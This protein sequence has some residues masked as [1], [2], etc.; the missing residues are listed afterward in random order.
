MPYC[1]FKVRH[2][3][4][5]IQAGR[6]REREKKCV[7]LTPSQTCHQQ[8]LFK[9]GVQVVRAKCSHLMQASEDSPIRSSAGFLGHPS[10]IAVVGRVTFIL[11]A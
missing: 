7:A 6:E 2:F 10:D 5:S 4:W 3:S 1:V 9:I 11:R 8:H